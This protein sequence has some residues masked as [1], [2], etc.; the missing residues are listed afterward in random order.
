MRQLH[1]KGL[2][3]KYEIYRGGALEE[4]ACYSTKVTL[5]YL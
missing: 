4:K 5:I 2:H 1:I 3:F